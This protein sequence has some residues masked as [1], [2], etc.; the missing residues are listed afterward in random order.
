MPTTPIQTW[1]MGRLDPFM[2]PDE[3]SE[4]AVNLL[5][6]TTF[7]KGTI[8]G[9]VTATAGV[10]RA[11]L[12]GA[13]DGSQ[14]PKGILRY[15]CVTD[16]SGYITLGGGPA[17][18]SEHGEVSRSTSIFYSGTFKTS[19]LTGL[20]ANAITVLQAHLISGSVANGILV[21]P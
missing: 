2:N 21:I 14:V 20:D 13:V 8:L 11:Y 5:P 10:Y 1:G 18:T 4:I 7:V 19:E 6:S 17:G 15:D 9:E 12:S 16:A 3:A